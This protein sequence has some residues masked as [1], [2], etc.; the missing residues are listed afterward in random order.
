VKNGERKERE[1][2]NISFSPVFAVEQ[3]T[4]LSFSPFFR[5]SKTLIFLL[6]VL[7]GEK[8]A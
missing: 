7:H 5:G 2:C 6:P 8:V 1:E 4:C 3:I